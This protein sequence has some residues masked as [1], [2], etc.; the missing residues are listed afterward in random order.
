M[1]AEAAVAKKKDLG[2]NSGGV[3]GVHQRTPSLW[4]DGLGLLGCGWCGYLGLSC[5]HT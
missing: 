1:W 3:G 4:R 2:L 5:D